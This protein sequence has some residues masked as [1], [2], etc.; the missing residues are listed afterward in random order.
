[1]VTAVKAPLGALHVD[2]N[3]A[4]DRWDVVDQDGRALAHCPAQCDAVTLAIR[5]ARR[6][7]GQGDDV[8]VCLEQADGHYALAW[9]PPRIHKR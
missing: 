8:V 1:M 7:H 6:R 9:S 3:P 5:E 4:S 2:R